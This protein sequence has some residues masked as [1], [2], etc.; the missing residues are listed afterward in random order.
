MLFIS[1][2]V[3]MR[4]NNSDFDAVLVGSG[5]NQTYTMKT[6]ETNGFSIDDFNG[7]G[8]LELE[9]VMIN[10]KDAYDGFSKQLRKKPKLESWKG[11]GKRK[12]V[13]K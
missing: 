3:L 13:I 8:F 5:D 1:H 9:K 11:E 10:G 2:D 6:K 12:K 7:S 4:I